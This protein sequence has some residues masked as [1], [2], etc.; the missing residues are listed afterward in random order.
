[1]SGPWRPSANRDSY[2]DR[3][4][5][6]VETKRRGDEVVVTETEPEGGVTRPRRWWSQRRGLDWAAP[7]VAARPHPFRA[8]SHPDQ[9][10]ARHPR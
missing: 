9:A 6:L 7:R 5:L 2:T 3:V 10:S 8:H 4:K 1:M